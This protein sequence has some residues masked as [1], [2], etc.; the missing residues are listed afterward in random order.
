MKSYVVWLIPLMFCPCSKTWSS[1]A[2][3]TLTIITYHQAEIPSDLGQERIDNLIREYKE[4]LP[5]DLQT[6][7]KKVPGTRGKIEF[8]ER[9]ADLIKLKKA[10]DY[11]NVSAL[12][13]TI[14]TIVSPQP[15]AFLFT[16]IET[17]G[18]TIVLRGKIVNIETLVIAE[19]RIE[20]PQSEAFLTETMD[21]RIEDLACGILKQ[22]QINCST[23][24][25]GLISLKEYIK[26]NEL[27]IIGLGLGFGY[28]KGDHV[29]LGNIPSDIRTIPPHP[30]DVIYRPNEILP[31]EIPDNYL[32]RE[33]A[34]RVDLGHR[35]SFDVHFSF[36][37]IVNIAIIT[38]AIRESEVVENQNLFRKNYIKPGIP[39]EALIFYSVKSKETQFFDGNSFS[40]PIYITYPVLYCGKNKGL[41]FRI[42]GGTNILLPDKIE[43]VADQ[44]WD[45]FGEKEIE[46]TI[47]LGELK[48]IE[49]FG[50][51][52]IEGTPAK[53][54]RLGI[55]FTL[56]YT[57]YQ[58]NSEGPLSLQLENSVR[59]S[60]RVNVTKLFRK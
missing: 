34:V 16:K 49:W 35:I 57:D 5:R 51:I 30:D 39:G 37:G 10:I 60:L 46:E 55:Q 4:K 48:E 40:L 59:P 12:I 8:L 31:P 20:F 22:V 53:D 24:D 27:Y 33:N 36:K 43:L 41:V 42:V 11:E 13:D 17:G 44:G 28:L 25:C 19:D 6:E 52:D 7:I 15:D 3:T 26:E 1:S 47:D 50:G 54:F 14:L 29:T 45:R 18:G 56:V 9:S 21:S 58:E 38:S 23:K 32:I 2:D